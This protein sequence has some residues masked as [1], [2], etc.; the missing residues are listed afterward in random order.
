MTGSNN[1]AIG[2]SA[3]ANSIGSGSIGIGSK[4]GEFVGSSNNVIAIGS[5]G[6]DVDNSCFISNIRDVTTQNADAMA[7]VIDSAGQLGTM[8]SSRQYKR[9]SSQ[10]IMPA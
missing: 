4:A 6:D 9:R 2:H 8:S 7:V 1:T 10:W 3:L 5:P